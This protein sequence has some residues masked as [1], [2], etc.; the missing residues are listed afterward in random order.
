MGALQFTV[1][2]AL[3][4]S[5]LQMGTLVSLRRAPGAVA[6]FMAGLWVDRHR[7]RPIMIATDLGR[8]AL[9]AFIPITYV[10]GELRIE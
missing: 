3:G 5:P 1:V 8:A 9:F 7:K 10:L 6:G 2:L 4:A